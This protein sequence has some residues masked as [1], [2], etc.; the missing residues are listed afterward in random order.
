MPGRH[1][2]FVHNKLFERS[3]KNI[4]SDEEMR[5]VENALLDDPEAGPVMRDTGGVR[6]IRAA[7]ENRGKSGSARVV[8]LY[9]AERETVYFLLA[10]AKNVQ[11]D[12]SPAEK[13]QLRTVVA[14]IRAETWP[15][16]KRWFRRESP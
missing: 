9:I 8:Y 12:L 15:T 4:L 5:A 3:R 10:F 7:Q 11:G 16:K 14:L 13:K 1:L 6:K 2:E